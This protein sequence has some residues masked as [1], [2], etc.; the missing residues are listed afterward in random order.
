MI[1][2]ILF[3]KKLSLA[4]SSDLGSKVELVKHADNSVIM[5]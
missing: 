5:R 1:S 2:S 3:P 4:N